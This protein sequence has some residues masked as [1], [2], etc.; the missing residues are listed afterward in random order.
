MKKKTMS[1][2]YGDDPKFSLIRENET[3]HIPSV[4]DLELKTPEFFIFL[5]IARE[6]N[7]TVVFDYEGWTVS[8]EEKDVF[9][10]MKITIYLALAEHPEMV[11]D[12]LNYLL[13]K[14]EA[15]L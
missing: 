15:I 4:Y 13:R 9:M 2:H 10:E 6:Q 8:P 5:G 1:E 3:V 11:K 14:Q 12:Y 7:C